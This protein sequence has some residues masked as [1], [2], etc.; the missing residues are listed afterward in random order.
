M[1]G[2]KAG[3]CRPFHS[4]AVP[5]K[6]YIAIC[7]FYPYPQYSLHTNLSRTQTLERV[8]RLMDKVGLSISRFPLNL[9]PQQ[10]SG[11]QRQRVM[12]AMAIACSPDILIADEP[13]SALDVTVQEQILDLIRE[14][15]DSSGMSLI[16]ISHDLGVIAQTTR[17]VMVMYTGSMLDFFSLDFYERL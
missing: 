14:L 16:M 9:Y 11:G 15:A 3:L 5:E 4:T 7:F 2:F 10:L 8:T 12:I 6:L 13:T 1:P 17:N